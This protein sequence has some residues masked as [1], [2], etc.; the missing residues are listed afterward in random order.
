MTWPAILL[1]SLALPFS[2][3][4]EF[5]IFGALQKYATIWSSFALETL[6]VDITITGNIIGIIQDGK[7]VELNVAEACAGFKG[8]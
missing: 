1:L 5:V 4:M 6:G 2:G 7:R 3:K 8:C